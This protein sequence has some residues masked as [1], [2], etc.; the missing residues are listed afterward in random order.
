MVEKDNQLNS[1]QQWV[2]LT[3]VF[4]ISFALLALEVVLTRVLSVVLSYHYVFAVVSLALLGL[5][6]GGVFV[7]LFRSHST[8]KWGSLSIFAAIFSL[9]IP[10][11][12]LLLT[13]VAY[14]TNPL[15]NTIFYFLLLFIPFFFAGI[16]LAEVFRIFPTLIP[17]IYGVDLLG[18]ATGSFGAILALNNIEGIK[19]S[20]L[21]A[22][23]AAIAALLMTIIVPEKKTKEVTLASISLAMALSLLGASLIGFYS[24]DI[25]IGTNPAKEIYR[26]VSESADEGKIIETEWSAFGRTDV[27]A[28]SQLPE[29]MNIYID[30]T[31]G[32]PMFQ[33]NGD[34]INPK[35]EKITSL[36]TDFLGYLP[37]S[38]LQEKEK[39]NALI[40]GPGGGRDILMALM[41]GVNHVTAVEINRD[42]INIMRQYAW[43][44]GGICDSDRVKVIVDEGRNFLKRQKEDYDI[45]LLSLPVTKTSR[46]LEGY[47]LTEN[48]LFTTD[49][50][51]DYLEHLTDEGRLIVITH[52]PN[53]IMRLLSL[54]LTTLKQ[55]GIDNQAAMKQIY[56]LSSELYPVF[57]MKKTPFTPA[58]MKSLSQTMSQLGYD[59]IQSYLPSIEQNDYPLSRNGSYFDER[60]TFALILNAIS[61]GKLDF[62]EFVKIVK[63]YGLDFSPVTDNNPFF[64]KLERGLPRPVSLVFWLSAVMTLLVILLPPLYWRKR[65]SATATLIEDNQSFKQ[66]LSFVVLFLML[67]VGFMLAEIS[68]FQ[69][70]VLFLGQPIISLATSLSSLLVGTGIGSLFSSRLPR[71]RLT[72]GIALVCLFVTAILL[73]YTFLFPLILNQ[74]LGLELTARL[75]VTAIL[76]V[77][78]GF[79][80]GFPFPLGLRLLKET[81]RENF[82]PWMWGINGISSVLGSTM[83]II[84]AISLGFTQALIVAA[85][86]YFILFLIFQTIPPKRTTSFSQETMMRRDKRKPNKVK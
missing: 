61:Q 8:G 66:S 37:L 78:L 63:E 39:N 51:S 77:P 15:G 84:I 79:L 27:V 9:A 81:K 46:S 41:A 53:E 45:I 73:S 3:S 29:K 64:Y 76:L 23:A 1:S 67:G 70:L 36:K 26:A 86:S 19:G 14:L 60:D 48:F 10:A 62:A 31:A 7:Y 58:E 4:L 83:A 24:P 43:Y 55:R 47:S 85:S 16:F 28:F 74:L 54:S 69:R 71:E 33:F 22:L 30:G 50:I 18:A 13:R 75:L 6:A 34:F 82:I 35:P 68:L 40:I 5:G 65:T 20:F 80:M 11:T 32:T 52:D 56:I 17:K 44:N 21:L 72:Q 38:V 25:P 12:T 2:L 57:V 42:L 49:S 59:V